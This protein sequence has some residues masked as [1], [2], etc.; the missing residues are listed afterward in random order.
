MYVFGGRAHLD[1]A[2]KKFTYVSQVEQCE[3]HKGKPSDWRVLNLNISP[4][5]IHGSIA[6]VQ[7][8]EDTILVIGGSRDD[9]NGDS[10]KLVT[11]FMPM[12]GEGGKFKEKGRMVEILAKKNLR[13]AVYVGQE[14][15]LLMEHVGI[16][17]QE[18]EPVYELTMD[19]ELT[20]RTKKGVK[21]L[22]QK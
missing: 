12:K 11:K 18:E 22:H 20:V 8:A 14:R 9:E 7:V 15:V 1:Y 2:S 13:N 3:L 16:Y 17:K 10:K 5:L 21:K 19:K 4:E 6:A